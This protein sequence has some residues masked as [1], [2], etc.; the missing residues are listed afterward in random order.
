MN[1]QNTELFAQLN[2]GLHFNLSNDFGIIRATG[3]DARSFLHSQFTQD[4]VHLSDTE[5]RLGAYCSAK[6]RMYAI[7]YVWSH[8]DAVYLLMHRSV[9]ETVIKRLRM[10]VLRAKVV[11]EDVSTQY[12]ITGYSGSDALANQVKQSDAQRTRLGIL[13]ASLGEW[14]QPNL[15]REIRITP[16]EQHQSATSTEFALWQWFDI[17]AGIAHVTADISES[18]V[19]QM[20]N[21]DRIGGVNFKKGCYPGQEIVARSH[22]LGKLKRRMQAASGMVEHAPALTVGMDVYSSLDAS[23]PAGQL[24]AFAPNPFIINRWDVLYEVSLPMLANDA[25]LRLQ[26]IESVWV[27]KSLPYTLTDE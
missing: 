5:A 4:I 2:A 19:P 26:T 1:T 22:Y 17:M 24:L 8:E 7:F 21:L 25:Q 9:I 18:F 11:L 20:M 16:M 27:H 3:E 12:V 15:A 23:Q 10:F 6:G 14:E 13:P